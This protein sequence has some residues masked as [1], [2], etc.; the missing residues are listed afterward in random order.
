MSHSAYDTV[1]SQDIIKKKKW[2]FQQNCHCE[3]QLVALNH[4]N[5]DAALWHGAKILSFLCTQL[6][7]SMKEDRN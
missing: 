3:N 7:I 5:V 1:N 4:N 6:W 2:L